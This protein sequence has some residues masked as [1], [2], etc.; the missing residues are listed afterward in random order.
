M[1]RYLFAVLGSLFAVGFVFAEDLTTAVVGRWTA[2]GK[3][4]E[5]YSQAI[6]RSVAETTRPSGLGT[7][8]FKYDFPSDG[9]IALNFGGG[10]TEPCAISIT[11]N[12]LHITDASQQ[13]TVYTKAETNLNPCVQNLR[14]LDGAMS[15][16]ALD[17][18]GMSA[19]GP[20]DLIPAYLSTLPTCPDGGIYNLAGPGGHP[21]CTIEGHSLGQ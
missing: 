19:N 18:D 20:G 14:Q 9:Q 13:E 8:Y 11:N 10:S 16:F 5:F 6:G 7:G 3:T 4:L 17:H 1:K 2:E 12:E 21:A 15:L